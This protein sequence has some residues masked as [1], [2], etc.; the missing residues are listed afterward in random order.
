MSML[1]FLEVFRFR[2]RD[3]PI[4]RMDPR[5]KALYVFVA[6]II[7]IIY[8][9]LTAMITIFIST[10]PLIAIA[11]VHREWIRSLRGALFLTSMIVVVNMFAGYLSGGLT[12]T[13]ET[14][15][16]AFSMGLRFLTFTSIFSIFFLTTTPE[17]LSLALEKLKVP[18]DYCFA[19]TSAI[20]F[21][22]DLA[23]EIQTVIDAQR[24]RGL[25]LEKG[26]IVRRIRN[27]IPIL[28]PVFIRSFTRSIELAEAMEARGYGASEKRTSIYELNMK[29]SDYAIAS[30]LLCILAISILLRVYANWY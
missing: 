8:Y 24:S 6:S 25:E 21:V 16:Y 2:R 10:I 29:H 9:S 28:I 13:V 19:F 4:H 23:L 12:L 15:S 11:K 27:Y 26:N 17:D 30:F 7:S 3:S 20:R 18:Y 1:S 14:V 22:P 5:V